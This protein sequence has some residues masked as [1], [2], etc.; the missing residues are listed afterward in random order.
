M[1]NLK[2]ANQWVPSE[3][4]VSAREAEVLAAL[5]EHLTNAEIG[6][7]LFISIRTVESHVS[8]SVGMSATSPARSSARMTRAGLT[9][10]RRADPDLP[11]FQ[12]PNTSADVA[13]RHAQRGRRPRPIA[14]RG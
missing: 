4:G 9:H 2:V 12:P 1:H 6:D 13:R 3:V 10:G 11:G 5:A 7:R 8:W 14:Q